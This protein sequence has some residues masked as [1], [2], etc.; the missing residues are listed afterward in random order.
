VFPIGIDR[1][2]IV[3][4]SQLK[5]FHCTC[6]LFDLKELCT[7]PK[8]VKRLRRSVTKFRLDIGV[9][10]LKLLEE[11]FVPSC[12]HEPKVLKGKPKISNKIVDFEN[13]KIFRIYFW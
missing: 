2:C 3:L 8:I 11:V 7:A 9:N 1:I 4:L 10:F 6:T 5:D 12:F 13:E